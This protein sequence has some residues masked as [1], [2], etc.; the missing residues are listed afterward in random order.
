MARTSQG[1][2]LTIQHR[3][4]QLSLRA[5]TL[6]DLM[7]LWRAVDP[8]NLRGTI[9][10]F[11]RAA[12]TI[13]RARFGDSAILAAR[14]YERFREVEGA[15]GAVTIVT[16][17]PPSRELTTGV[18]RGAALSGIVNARRRGQSVQAASQNGL[19]KASG[20]IS[21]LVLSASRQVITQATASDP[22]STGR[23]ARV[24][25]GSAC[26]FCLMLESRGA[27]FSARTADFQSHDHCACVAEPAFSD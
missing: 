10:P 6:R 25:G 23:W 11:T 26:E 24:A 9:D 19:V 13:I 5:A 22:R 27:V 17:D 3:Q 1:Q 2:Q 18:V 7:A 8:T 12:A 20:S 15:S 16:P 14:Y 4:R 21:N